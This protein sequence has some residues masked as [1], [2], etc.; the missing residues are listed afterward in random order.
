M[1]QLELYVTLHVSKIVPPIQDVFVQKVTKMIELRKEESQE[2][3]KGW[4]TQEQVK[5]ELKWS[6]M[7][8]CTHW[9]LWGIIR[10]P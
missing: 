6:T 2:I 5:S 3:L 9:D 8:C 1:Y 7:L 10:A 4:F